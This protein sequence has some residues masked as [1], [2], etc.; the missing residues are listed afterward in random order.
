MTKFTMPALGADMETGTLV[1]WKVREGDRVHSGDVVAVVETHKGA[2]DVECF[3]DGVIENLA[4][5]HVPMPVGAV[6]AQVRSTDRV[7][8][9][10]AGQGAAPPDLTPS[11]QPQTQEPADGRAVPPQRAAA[12]EMP[13]RIRASPAAR[14]LLQQR[15]VDLQQ[16]QG[17]P[18]A[19]A[20]LTL[21]AVQSLGTPDPMRVAIAQA[22][23]R[24][25]REIPHYYL[26]T[27]VDFDAAQRWLIQWNSSREPDDRLLP[28]VLLLKAMARALVEYPQFNG[29]YENQEFEPGASVHVGWVIALR[30]GGLVVPALRDAA[31]RTLPDLMNGLR[32]LVQRAR[33]GHLRSSELTDA[34]VTVTSLGER[35]AESV[36]GVIYPPQV[37]LVGFGGLMERPW[38]VD[39][40]VLPR[41][42]ISVSLAG[43]HRVSDG[44]SGSRFLGAIARGL[45]APHTL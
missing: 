12:P 10:T 31:N 34:T 44:H 13:R 32:G 39:G 18:D 20:P 24:S 33:S 26:T 36:L 3:L 21:A 2:I 4:P 29:R 27:T 35:G 19:D 37:A 6:L 38:V 11:T 5:L 41:L 16:L 45:Q 28:A 43:D 25:K 42:V 30:G 15:G 9:Q 8:E 7:V 23:S 22:V 17:L 40:E 1:E 14:R